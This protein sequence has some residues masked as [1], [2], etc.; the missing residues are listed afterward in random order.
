VEAG[1]TQ[2]R[3]HEV[4]RYP[5]TDRDQALFG[6]IRNLFTIS[7][8]GEK[9][10]SLEAGINPIKRSLV[11]GL[12]PAILLSSSPWKAGTESTPW[13]D[14]FDLDRGHVRYFGDHKASTTTP[15]GSTPGNAALLEEFARHRGGTVDDRRQ[16]TPLLL[17]RAV[18]HEGVQK[19]FREFCSGT[20]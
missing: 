18:S 16:A 20:R 4:V 17:F 2:V 15:L 3:M 1:P 6:S 14:V 10:I 13:H 7:A 8:G 5:K 19:G 9:L 12:R 11:S